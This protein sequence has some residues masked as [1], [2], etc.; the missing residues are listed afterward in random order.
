MG[1]AVELGLAVGLG[2][3]VGAVRGFSS[4]FPLDLGAA[5]LV[6]AAGLGVGFSPKTPGLPSSYKPAI[7]AIIIVAKVPTNK[8][9]QPNSEISLRREGIKAIVPPTKI[10]TD[11]KWANPDRA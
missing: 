6:V 11:A 5:G 2:E 8:A 1:L 7:Q 3:I 10:P 4:G 9:F